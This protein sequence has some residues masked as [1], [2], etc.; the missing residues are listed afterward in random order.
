MTN[1]Q[2]VL[3]P[4]SSYDEKFGALTQALRWEVADELRAKNLARIN[5]TRNTVAPKQTFYVRYGKRVLDVLAAGAALVATFPISLVLAAGIARDVGSPVVFSQRRLGKDGK[6]FVLP[7]FKTMRDAYDEDGRPLLGE[8]RVTRLGKIIRRTSLDELPNFWSVLK[9]D[10]SLIGPRPLVPEYLDRFSD[11]HRARLAV[12][13]GIECPPRKPLG[14]PATY[15]DQFENDVWYV[16]N[17]SLSTDLRLLLGIARSVFDRKQSALRS[18]SARGSF[19][20]Y[21]A[22]GTVVT[23][24]NIP[25]WALDK[26]LIRHGLMTAPGTPETNE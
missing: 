19:L 24:D 7:K 17:V 8:L 3:T 9:G 12:R 1:T 21:N 18:A 6:P 26:V 23:T 2:A 20:G 16:E 15:G 5:T 4:A 13:P 11:R 22:D 14:R 25:P 10:M